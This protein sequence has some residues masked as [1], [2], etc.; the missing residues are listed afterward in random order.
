MSRP[1]SSFGIVKVTDDPDKVRTVVGPE[2]R[3]CGLGS[4]WSNRKKLAANTGLG[5]LG[6]NGTKEIGN[7]IKKWVRRTRYVFTGYGDDLE[8][9]DRRSGGARAGSDHNSPSLAFAMS[10][11]GVRL[12]LWLFSPHPSISYPWERQHSPSLTPP[13]EFGETR[14]SAIL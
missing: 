5:K 4:Q 2:A 12:S 9:I 1:F 13:H 14:D 6:W 3:P 11:A 7:P 10:Q 8:V